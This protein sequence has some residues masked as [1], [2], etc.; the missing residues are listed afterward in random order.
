MSQFRSLLLL[1]TFFTMAAS[2][3]LKYTYTYN[4]VNFSLSI[5][6]ISFENDSISLRCAIVFPLKYI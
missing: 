3:V 2:Y 4:P 6:L 1:I 5:N